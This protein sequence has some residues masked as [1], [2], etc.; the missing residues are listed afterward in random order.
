MP[1]C[2]QSERSEGAGEWFRPG[3]V[4]PG[5]G[6]AKLCLPPGN[7]GTHETDRRLRVAGGSGIVRNE[8]N[9]DR[10]GRR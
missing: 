3:L 9:G 10:K 8:S 2:A 5:S 1:A 7:A 4:S 6:S